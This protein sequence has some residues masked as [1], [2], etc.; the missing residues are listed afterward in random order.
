MA[1]GARSSQAASS[2]QESVR[3]RPARREAWEEYN[4]DTEDEMDQD[5]LIEVEDE[6][7]EEEEEEDEESV[8]PPSLPPRRRP[9][10]R[11]QEEP[12][13]VTPPSRPRRSQP[14]TTEE[15]PTGRPEYPTEREARKVASRPAAPKRQAYAALTGSEAPFPIL[16]LLRSHDPVLST[17][18]ELHG[19]LVVF[20][21]KQL[22][23]GLRA[24]RALGKTWRRNCRWNA[25]MF[26]RELASLWGVFG[27]ATRYVRA[28][29]GP[30]L[31]K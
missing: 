22:L 7:E 1:R 24:R 27:A 19:R 2:P 13:P 31:F 26:A 17:A 11:R 14:R 28:D 4:L 8:P 30:P 9:S 10:S 18:W 5:D 16:G 15:H 29:K 3:S 25:N 23:W 6:E 20:K 12:P 21:W